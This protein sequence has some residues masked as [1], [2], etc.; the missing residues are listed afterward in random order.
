MRGGSD[1]EQAFAAQTLK[2]QAFFT[3]FCVENHYIAARGK[4][5]GLALWVKDD[6]A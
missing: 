4:G 2:D 5:G 3:F 1:R 6:V